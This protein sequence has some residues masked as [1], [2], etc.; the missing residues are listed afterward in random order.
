MKGEAINIDLAAAKWRATTEVQFRCNRHRVQWTSDMKE[1]NGSEDSSLS[2]SL[3]Y[4]SWH[5]LSPLHLLFVG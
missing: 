4:S 2:S 5:W 1:S 3:S